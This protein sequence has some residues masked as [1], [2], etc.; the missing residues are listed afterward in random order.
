M[1]DPISDICKDVKNE[2]YESA[3]L[4][5]S[6]FFNRLLAAL[7]RESRMG[8]GIREVLTEMI[9]GDT[10]YHSIIVHFFYYMKYNEKKY[11]TTKDCKNQIIKE[12]NA[13]G[14]HNCQKNNTPYVYLP[15]NFNIYL[16]HSLS[17]AIRDVDKALRSHD[18]ILSEDILYQYSQLFSDII[19]GYLQ[20][21]LN[22]NT[23][24]IIWLQ[25]LR[26][27]ALLYRYFHL[28]YQKRE[29]EEKWKNITRQNRIF[30][31][32]N[33]YQGYFEKLQ[34]EAMSSI[35]KSQNE[36]NNLWKILKELQEKLTKEQAANNNL[37]S[38]LNEILNKK[39]NQEAITDVLTKV[40]SD[41]RSQNNDINDQTRQNI[42]TFLTNEVQS[43]TRNI[44]NNEDIIKE[45]QKLKKDIDDN[46]DTIEKL[47]KKLYKESKD[48]KDCNEA[49]NKLKLE[50]QS[51]DIER[52]NLNERIIKLQHEAT[53]KD[54]QLGDK[55]KGLIKCDK[56]N[57]ELKLEIERLQRNLTNKVEEETEKLRE[58][59]N[60]ANNL[61]REVKKLRK[62]VKENEDKYSECD[63]AKSEVEI[64]NE[65]LKNEIKK[66]RMEMVKL[67]KHQADGNDSLKQ[68]K[69]ELAIKIKKE[70]S[71]RQDM[72]DEHKKE[73][74]NVKD[75]FE[76]EQK[77]LKKIHASKVLELEGDLSDAKGKL[78]N[79]KDSFE[80]EQKNL[81]KIHADKLYKLERDLL[82]TK[83]ELEN[84]K[85]N[86]ENEQK[87][88][89]KIN[90]DKVS[91]LEKEAK[92][93][94]QIYK[95]Q[96]DQK[97]KELRD[98]LEAKVSIVEN[99]KLEL[100]TECSNTKQE[101][102]M[103]TIELDKLKEEYKNY[104]S[105]AAKNLSNISFDNIRKIESENV[106]KIDYL[107]NE[108]AEKNKLLKEKTESIEVLND[109]NNKLRIKFD[110]KSKI[111]YNLEARLN[112]DLLPIYNENL[113][114][115]DL[116]EKLKDTIKVKDNLYEMLKSELE[117]QVQARN[118]LC[119]EMDSMKKES[120]DKV[121]SENRKPLDYTINIPTPHHHHHPPPPPPPPHPP[122]PLPSLDID[123]HKHVYNN[124]EDDVYH[125]S[126]ESKKSLTGG[127]ENKSDHLMGEKKTNITD[128]TKISMIDSGKIIEQDIQSD[129]S[130]YFSTM[131]RKKEINKD[132]DDDNNA[133]KR[134]KE[135][136]EPKPEKKKVIKPPTSLSSL[137]PITHRTEKKVKTGVDNDDD[138][139]DIENE[140]ISVIGGQ[141]VKRKE[142]L[143]KPQQK[144]K[145]KEKNTGKEVVKHQQSLQ[146]NVNDNDYRLNKD[147]S[148]SNVEQK[149]SISNRDVDKI[150]KEE[151]HL[152]I[153][154]QPLPLPQS[155]PLPSS[156]PKL[157]LDDT[158]LPSLP[159]PPKKL[160]IDDI[161]KIV[162][163]EIAEPLN[164]NLDNNKERL[165]DDHDN[166]NL[167][168]SESIKID[169]NE[170]KDGN[171]SPQ[172]EKKSRSVKRK[173][174]ESDLDVKTIKRARKG[175]DEKSLSSFPKYTENIL[176]PSPDI[177]T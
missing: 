170:K 40:I 116:V 174:E 81:K 61:K 55:T 45:N 65:G 14:L 34:R 177:D 137:S 142:K 2:N 49:Q 91:E 96:S 17:V 156:L 135:D 103:K 22:T 134:I 72:I 48:L 80:N 155:P 101:L 69:K 111:A 164:M 47:Q 42:N 24:S 163:T 176:V 52:E 18:I 46:K 153:S 104:L 7:F 79:V 130:S 26:L 76:N 8:N 173:L 150:E 3:I 123:T 31:L 29:Q 67:E 114:L 1:Y 50:L 66:L 148:N 94:L 6:T 75:S 88:L 120:D 70:I 112:N 23:E 165:I 53:D 64:R 71:D 78:E 87:K 147:L 85:D 167:T 16:F 107:S 83:V 74:E 10:N 98:E 151:T 63:L 175:I 57:Q 90:A 128:N 122:H 139:D 92:K 126:D 89:K 35:Q 86:F 118:N 36:Y 37:N 144:T 162:N 131:R 168:I 149:S 28:S 127:K 110:E 117:E 15:P 143:S 12:N 152:G 119:N 39:E 161:I 141:G 25:E 93:E 160:E 33:D 140:S 159:R 121:K 115:K 20:C 38:Q 105:N 171:I 5:Y 9:H 51:R 11:I 102:S 125:H 41:L 60:D 109:M 99:Q 132:N 56:E 4:Q 77:N 32:Q 124:N 21:N 13:T 43:M 82:D 100:Y 68:D 146:S 154:P 145:K 84:V 158:Q 129:S 138:D 62:N 106:A 108:I 95:K 19:N 136:K 172:Y 97:I 58:Y 166:S 157:Q 30:E 73:L 169:D 44:Q 59:E 54:K 113:Y 133:K 27:I